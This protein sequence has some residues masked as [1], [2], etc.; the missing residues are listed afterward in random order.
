MR[1]F[2]PGA[3]PQSPGTVPQCDRRRLAE[4]ALPA[5]GHKR[6]VIITWAD[7]GAERPGHT[8]GSSAQHHPRHT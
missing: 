4:R 6:T 8:S 1:T 2:Q 5:H 3:R 7:Y